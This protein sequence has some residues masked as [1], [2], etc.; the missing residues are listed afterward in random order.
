V[1]VYLK[2]LLTENFLDKK[3]IAKNIF[4][5][6]KLNDPVINKPFGNNYKKFNDNAIGGMDNRKRI[7]KN[8]QNITGSSKGTTDGP[9][10]VIT[11]VKNSLNNNLNKDK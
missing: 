10:S 2:N 3:R 5:P 4:N 11:S 1:K 7:N 8:I 9:K 6:S